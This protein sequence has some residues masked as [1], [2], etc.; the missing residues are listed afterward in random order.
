MARPLPGGA[1][2]VP[3]PC[4]WR[5]MAAGALGACGLLLPWAGFNLF[6][7]LPAWSLHVSLAAVPLAGHA[8]YGELDLAV[9]L[10]ALVSSGRHGW[11]RT[12]TV[13][14]CGMALIGLAAA[15][16]VTTRVA[17]G[18]LMFRLGQDAQ[19]IAL[20]AHRGV[21]LA[22]H[23]PSSFIGLGFDA[24]TTL[25][26]LSL[27]LGWYLS[28][29]AGILLTGARRPAPPRA[30]VAAL[31]AITGLLA[32]SGTTLGLAGEQDKL[33]GA[34]ALADGLPA[35]ALERMKAALSLSPQLAYDPLVEQ[36]TGRADLE[37]GAPT[38]LALYA[39]ATETGAGN[40]PALLRNLV[41]LAKAASMAPANPVI[42][43]QYEQS[44]A[45][46]TSVSGPLV[47]AYASQQSA[48]VV[49]A[50]SLG[51]S[52]YDLGDNQ[53]AI[54]YMRAAEA[55]TPNAELRSS[56]LTYVALAEDRMG[57]VVAFRRD[58]VDAI[59]LDALDANALA[60]DAAAGLFL[61]SRI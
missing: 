42:A 45:T 38:A 58:I 15:Y 14:W 23:P 19:D 39:R 56:A 6:P 16:V 3:K 24:Q 9:L 5:M 54:R 40:Q 30:P 22:A 13:R 20:L 47:F 34:Q 31:L 8:T 4:R 36:V 37:L 41:L 59:G 53:L 49:V 44:L 57:E 29:V 11:A 48:S 26:V 35:L 12:T 51:R 21:A 55:D 52:F 2:P 7:S 60:R 43:E 33:A 32:V 25:L 17:G 61:P 10:A 28:V 18:R 50:Y 46:A 27:R 1:G